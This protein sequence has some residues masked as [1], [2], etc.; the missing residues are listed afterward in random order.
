MILKLAIRKNA[1]PL[2]FEIN[3][4]FCVKCLKGNWFLKFMKFSCMLCLVCFFCKQKLFF[5]FIK[6]S[7][8]DL[9]V[10]KPQGAGKSSS[11]PEESHWR[12]VELR[13]KQRAMAEQRGASA[14]TANL[15]GASAPA[16]AAQEE[17]VIGLS[18][19][20]ESEQSIKSQND[21]DSELS[22]APKVM[23]AAVLSA[24]HAHPVTTGTSKVPSGGDVHYSSPPVP[25]STWPPTSPKQQHAVFRRDDSFYLPSSAE[26][27]ESLDEEDAPPLPSSAPP[28]PT[29][30]MPHSLV[31]PSRPDASVSVTPSVDEQTFV[32]KAV[33]LNTASRRNGGKVGSSGAGEEVQNIRLQT[34]SSVGLSIRQR[35]AQIEQ[36]LKV[37]TFFGFILL[38]FVARR[39]KFLRSWLLPKLYDSK[40]EQSYIFFHFSIARQERLFCA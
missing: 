5:I 40:W 31:T 4:M 34:T 38:C 17:L 37:L 8:S 10:G 11:E 21:T 35:I 39:G 33:L 14:M 2:V 6:V 30:S 28:L 1:L 22:G 32:S 24:L 12:K 27:A 26:S 15:P 13:Q 7:A 18:L 19:P 20:S 25:K 16:F 23:R 3:K 36:Q 9:S 29:S